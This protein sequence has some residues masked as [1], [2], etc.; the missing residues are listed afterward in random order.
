L[1]GLYDEAPGAPRRIS[2][3]AIEAVIVRTLE[4]TRAGATH[5][6]LRGMAKGGWPRRTM[7]SQIWRAFGLSAASERNVSSSRT[8]HSLIEKARDIVGLYMN[9]PERAAVFCFDEK[10]QIQR[11]T[12]RRPCLPM[13]PGKSERRTHDYKRHGTTTLFAAL[14]VTT[15]TVITQFHAGT[16]R[17]SFASSSKRSMP[18]CHG[19]SM[20]T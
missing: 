20:S 2:D 5:W 10:I 12:G 1:D 18:P 3:D 4:E 6:S 11:S 14:N 9:P 7:I 15:S 19:G 16:G 13:R 8:T 17:S